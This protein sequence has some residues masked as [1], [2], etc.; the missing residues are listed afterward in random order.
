MKVKL[1]TPEQK[2]LLVG[3]EITNSH[4]YNPSQDAEGNW[5]ISNEECDQTSNPDYA[6]IKELSEIDYE[7]IPFD[8]SQF[9]A[10]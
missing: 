8:L 4:F 2:D 9:N 5:F 3:A 10:N 6:W 7:P 1:L